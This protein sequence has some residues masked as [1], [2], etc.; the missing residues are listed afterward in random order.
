MLSEIEIK[1]PD[2]GDFADVEVIELLV[3][4]GDTVQ[5]EDPLLSLE[6]DKAAMEVPSPHSGVIRELRVSVGDRVSEGTVVAILTIE[7]QSEVSQAESPTAPVDESSAE[8]SEETVD[9]AQTDKNPGAK[10]TAAVEGSAHHEP[11]ASLPPPVQKSGDSVPHASPG[12]R[13]FA[14]EL[15]ADL[16]QI[17]G[18]GPKGRIIKEDVKNWIKQRLSAPITASS[19][20]PALGIPPIPEVDFSRFGETETVS[21]GRIQKLSGQHLQRAWLNIPHVTQHDEADI[22]ELEEFR[23]SLKDEAAQE[24]VRVT[25]LG[26]VLKILVSALKKFPRFNASLNPGGESL[27]LKRYFHIGVA[28]DTPDGLVVPVIRDV[29][30]KTIL[31]LAREL[32]E[33]SEKARNGKLSPADMQG[34]CISVSS[35]GGIGGTAFTPIVNAPEVAILGLSR[36]RLS[37]VW[38]PDEGSFQPRLMLPMSLSYDHRVIDGAEAARFCAYLTRTLADMRR[39][40]L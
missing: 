24:G 28:V 10:P 34:G 35:L 14:R 17:H 30:Q 27:T 9:N 38:N 8:T 33:I 1:I 21:L 18:S 13:R 22:T 6:S 26:F 2:I 15:G 37:P 7:D 3:A 31:E 5:I 40:M 12:I 11:P 32:G 36:S 25:L 4:P 29:D 16:T 20:G 23:R 39:I 19:S